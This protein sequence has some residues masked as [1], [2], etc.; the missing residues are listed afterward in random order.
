MHSS[1][2]ITIQTKDKRTAQFYWAM[3][4]RY[5]KNPL[6]NQPN[7]SERICQEINN[8]VEKLNRDFDRE[9]FIDRTIKLADTYLLPD[10]EI[11]WIDKSNKRLINWLWMITNSNFNYSNFISYLDRPKVSYISNLEPLSYKANNDQ[12]I[13]DSI[14]ENIYQKYGLSQNPQCTEEMYELILKFL[15]FILIPTNYKRELIEKLKVKWIEIS[16]FEKFTWLNINKLEQHAWALDY[17]DNYRK[18]ECNLMLGLRPTSSERYY[19][20]FISCIDSWQTTNDTKELFFIKIKKA[21][22][23]KKHRDKLGDKKPYSFNLSSTTKKNLDELSTKLGR[24]KNEILE[25]LINTK[26][27]QVTNK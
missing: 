23:Q 2:K 16:N 22:N 25:E 12:F 17:I 27:Q 1:G 24:H 15:D 21:W 9:T 14:N 13:A 7:S 26:Y 18:N 10:S 11:N 8:G 19:E 3:W 5:Q 6:M 20:Y 4:A